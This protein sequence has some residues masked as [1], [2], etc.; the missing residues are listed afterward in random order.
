MNGDTVIGSYTYHKLY[1]PY[2]DVWGSCNVIH[3]FGYNGSIRQDIGQKKVYYITQ[4]S[5]T[6]VLLYDF[7]LQMGDSIQGFS[8]LNCS[9]PSDTITQ[10]DSVLIGNN[11]R[12]RWHFGAFGAQNSIIEGIGFYSGLLEGCG[13]SFPNVPY[14]SLTC[15]SQDAQTLYPDSTTLCSI[16]LKIENDFVENISATIYPNPIQNSSTFVVNQ[17]FE[18]SEFII[19]DATGRIVEQ[20]RLKGIFNTINGQDLINGIYFYRL[21]NDQGKSTFGKFIVD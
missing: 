18:N 11:Y 13:V 8:R 7:N 9:Q 3:Q 1:I 19:Y 15:F 6:E 20:K 5:S 14:F 12:K 16:V 21:K 4:N 17:I 2:V 10:V